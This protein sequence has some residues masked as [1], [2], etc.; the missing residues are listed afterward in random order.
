[1]N[2]DDVVER[3]LGASRA[4][5]D[6]AASAA[7]TLRMKLAR[8]LEPTTPRS[9]C[10]RA[11]LDLMGGV[12]INI[13]EAVEADRALIKHIAR[14]TPLELFEIVEFASEELVGCCGEMLPMGARDA[15]A[16][17]S[18]MPALWLSSVPG[19]T[20][21]ITGVRVGEALHPE[22]PS[23]TVPPPSLS[24]AAGSARV[25]AEPVAPPPP[26]ADDEP[27]ARLL[28]DARPPKA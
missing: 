8:M 12:R 15:A 6:G 21:P 3:A 25:A 20:M 2:A 14:S 16:R 27:P 18:R 17:C 1:M 4:R 5:A 11:H 22:P 13:A 10:T 28:G 23:P 9:S 26:R 24:P 7:V 19:S